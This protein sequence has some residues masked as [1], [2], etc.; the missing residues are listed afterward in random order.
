MEEDIGTPLILRRHFLATSRALI[1]M[2][3]GELM[4]RTPP[5]CMS[6]NEKLKQETEDTFIKDEH[7]PSMNKA[8]MKSNKSGQEQEACADKFPLNQ[9]KLEVHYSTV[10]LGNSNKTFIIENASSR[11]FDPP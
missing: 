5:L 2:E 8:Q 1:D 3:S 6:V 7:L 10:I 9:Q 11:L 4:M